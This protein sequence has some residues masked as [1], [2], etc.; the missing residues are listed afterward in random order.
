[1]KIRN[2]FR[3]IWNDGLTDDNEVLEQLCDDIFD[4]FPRGHQRDVWLAWLAQLAAGLMWQDA[5]KRW[6]VH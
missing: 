1:M 3:L 2:R 5:A 4:V 6:R